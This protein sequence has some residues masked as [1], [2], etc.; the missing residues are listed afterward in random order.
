[1]KIDNMRIIM[2]KLQ[3]LLEKVD[4]HNDH[5][6]IFLVEQNYFSLEWSVLNSSDCSRL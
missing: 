5:S 6:P 4:R 1:M 3:F 2:I